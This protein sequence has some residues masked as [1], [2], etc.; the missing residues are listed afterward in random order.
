MMSVL[1]LSAS[2]GR[3][4]KIEDGSPAASPPSVQL[5]LNLATLSGIGKKRERASGIRVRL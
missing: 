5:S 1:W 3:K 2:T 4:E